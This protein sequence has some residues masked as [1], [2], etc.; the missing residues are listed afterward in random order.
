MSIHGI[1][2]TGS[3]WSSHD[4]V[5]HYYQRNGRGV[6]LRETR[7][8][9]N[10][11]NAYFSEVSERLKTQISAAARQNQNGTFSDSFYNSYNMTGI[12]FSLGDTVIGGEFT[13]QTTE[14]NGIVSFSGSLEF[15]LSDEFADP[16][17]IGVEILDLGETLYENLHGPLDDY[18]RGRPNGSRRLGIHT[19]EPY[20]ITDSWG[21]TFDGQIYLEDTRSRY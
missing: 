17:D 14:I 20:S 16:L 5:S 8:L 4:F 11:A 3:P 21:G 9:T 19:G 1:S 10:V 18:L 6:T 15:Y 7:H 13:G 12:V 2:D